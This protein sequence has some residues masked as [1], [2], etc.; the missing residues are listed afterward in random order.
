MRG[1]Y[2]ILK[3]KLIEQKCL[4]SLDECFIFCSKSKTSVCNVHMIKRAHIGLREFSVE[5][6]D[7]L[8]MGSCRSD[9]RLRT[10]WPT[11]SAA[12]AKPGIGTRGFPRTDWVSRDSRLSSSAGRKLKPTAPESKAW[13]SDAA[14]ALVDL[15]GWEAIEAGWEPMLA[16]AGLDWIV[17][18]FSGIW[19][20]V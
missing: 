16:L 12:A 1:M 3:Q 20:G 6:W 15:D 11:A 5:R 8:K 14:A 7:E 4:I 17:S 2:K 18:Y 13:I 10:G 19:F 9:S